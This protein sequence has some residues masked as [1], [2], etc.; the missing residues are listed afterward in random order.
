LFERI[1]VSDQSGM[2]RA[3][4][5]LGGE[6]GERL[7]GFVREFRIGDRYTMK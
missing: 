6:R 3:G 7:R 2:Q 1:W 4:L 5:T